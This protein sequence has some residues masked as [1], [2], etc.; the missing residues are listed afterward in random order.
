MSKATVDFSLLFSRKW[1]QFLNTAVLF[2]RIV[3]YLHD[4]NLGGFQ[5]FEQTLAQRGLGRDQQ[6]SRSIHGIALGN[7]AG[8]QICSQTRKRCSCLSNPCV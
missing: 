5:N 6:T 7:H 2:E 4:R 3:G 1:W 8:G